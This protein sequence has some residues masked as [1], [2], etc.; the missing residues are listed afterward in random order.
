MGRTVPELMGVFW[1]FDMSDTYTIT[2][3]KKQLEVLT[4]ASEVLA[5]L[6]T[7]QFTMALEWLPFKKGFHLKYDTI[8]YI[9][10]QLS[11]FLLQDIDGWRS[12]LGINNSDVSESAKIAWDLH[13]AFRK[14]LAWERAVEQGI[15]PSLDSPRKWPEMLTVDFDN[16]M[17][18]SNEPLP[19]FEETKYVPV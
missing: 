6:G 8:L 9:S 5:R 2:I 10:N 11:P 14:R 16:P 13:Q 18:T 15:V 12:S 1:C 17:V 19:T 4:A 3:T 7:G